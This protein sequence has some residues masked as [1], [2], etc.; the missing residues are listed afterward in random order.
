M[1]QSNQQSGAVLKAGLSSGLRAQGWAPDLSQQQQARERNS[2]KISGWDLKQWAWVEIDG[3]ASSLG[4]AAFLTPQ[5]HQTLW[6]VCGEA[7]C[8]SQRS[9]SLSWTPVPGEGSRMGL[10]LGGVC[11][12]THRCTVHCC[13]RGPP[14]CWQVTLPSTFCILKM[15]RV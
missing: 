8:A 14:S 6:P 2:R 15:P 10:G 1:G 13:Y 12:G 3:R 11:P 7:Q 5:G 9:S 4:R